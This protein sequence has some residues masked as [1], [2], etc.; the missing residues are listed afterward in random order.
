MGKKQVEMAICSCKTLNLSSGFAFIFIFHDD[1]TLGNDDAERLLRQFPGSEIISRSA[2]DKM[3]NEK[4]EHYPR[5]KYLRGRN[6]FFLKLF[7]IFLCSDEKRIAQMDSDIL[8]FKKPDQFISELSRMEGDSLFNMDDNFYYA[9]ALDLKTFQTLVGRDV[10]TRINAGLWVLDR[11]VLN[12][13]LLEKWLS[14]KIIQDIL[15]LDLLE[16]SLI[17]ALA[18]VYKKQINYFFSQEYDA[19]LD[20][21]PEN[22][23][24]G[25]YI[26]PKREQFELQGLKYWMKRKRFV[27]E[28]KKFVK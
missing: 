7:D 28:W 5:C 19:N 15:N 6:I 24:C 10:P 9:F 21:D 4:L 27:K 17:A 26:N 23:I 3:I 2:S 8:F 25:H 22:M 1:G 13:D 20:K 11:K 14:S 12:L 18:G 16:Q